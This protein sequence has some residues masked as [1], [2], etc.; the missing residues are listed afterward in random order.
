[1]VEATKHADNICWLDTDCEVRTDI[2]SIFSHIVFNKLCMVVDQPWTTRRGEKW[3]NSGVVAFTQLPVI[4]NHW[5]QETQL[6]LE[7]KDPMYG[8]QDVLHELVRTGMN[9]IV[10]I[11][12]LPKQYNTLRL[13][14]LSLIHI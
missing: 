14:I 8:D 3:H 5:F 2:S 9:R 1:M 13:D 12:D 7:D 4:L 6:I 11:T 10:H